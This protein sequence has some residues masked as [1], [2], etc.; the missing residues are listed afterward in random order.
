MESY[1]DHLDPVKLQKQYNFDLD[2]WRAE[3]TSSGFKGVYF[4]EY[5]THP[6]P[7]LMCFRRQ[8]LGKMAGWIVRWV[9]R[10]A[11]ILRYYK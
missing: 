3:S 5:T 9:H 1:P 4:R 7:L 11:R 10:P 8:A 6:T 2:Q